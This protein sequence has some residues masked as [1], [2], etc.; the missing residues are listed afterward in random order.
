MLAIFEL[1]IARGFYA[2]YC[3]LHP[4]VN[5]TALVQ[6]SKRHLL[7]PSSLLWWQVRWQSCSSSDMTQALPENLRL[8]QELH[9]KKVK[10]NFLT[11]PKT[12]AS[13]T[14][15]QLFYFLLK[16]RNFFLKSITMYFSEISH[17]IRCRSSGNILFRWFL[18]DNKNG[19]D[20]EGLHRINHYLWGL[21]YAAARMCPVN[22]QLF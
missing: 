8:D 2:L 1:S 19:I 6:G 3:W 14:V 16:K 9:N 17:L 4:A 15:V 12:D 22:S 7:K 11:M 20:S 10:F 5:V 18:F 13:M 21:F